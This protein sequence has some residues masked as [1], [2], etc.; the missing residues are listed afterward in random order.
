M[1]KLFTIIEYLLRSCAI[2]KKQ[3]KNKSS[4]GVKCRI[5]SLRRTFHYVMNAR[6]HEPRRIVQKGIRQKPQQ[7]MCC[8]LCRCV[9]TCVATVRPVRS[10]VLNNGTVRFRHRLPH[11]TCKSTLALLCIK[12]YLSLIHLANT[13]AFLV[14]QST[15]RCIGQTK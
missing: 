13:R 10:A 11:N 15:A 4:G 6:P 1:F 9:V 12:L 8:L 2:K 14:S 3:P 7:L 5:R